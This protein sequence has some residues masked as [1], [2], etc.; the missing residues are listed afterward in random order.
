M[1]TNFGTFSFRDSFSVHGGRGGARRTPLHLLS[2][3]DAEGHGEHLYTSLH[4]GRGG[5]R[6]TPFVRGGRGGARRTSYGFCPRRFAE[7][8]GEHLYTF[9]PRRTRGG[10]RRTSYGFCPR[11]YAEGH[12]EHLYTFCPRRTRRGTENF[13]RLL[14]AE[15][16]EGHGELPTA[17]VHGGLRGGAHGEHLYTFCPRRARRGTENFLRLLSTEVRGGARRTPLHLLSAEGA[18]NDF[19]SFDRRRGARGQYEHLCVLFR[20]LRACKCYVLNGIRQLSR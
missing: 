13:L 6:R 1:L 8:H 17:F 16:A 11:R 5:A 15:G 19:A 7:G 3:E 10:A 18:E 14:S 2:A 4:G 20:T 9:C 12:G